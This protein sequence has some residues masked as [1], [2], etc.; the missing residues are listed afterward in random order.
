MTKAQAKS[1]KQGDQVRDRTGNRYSVSE[2]ILTS[3]DPRDK[4]PLLVIFPA[5]FPRV[6]TGQVWTY[7]LLTEVK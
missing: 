3:D 7:R 6:G 1:L 5:Y 4:T 2:V